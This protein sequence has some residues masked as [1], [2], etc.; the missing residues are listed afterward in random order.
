MRLGSKVS[1]LELL[2]E[3]HISWIQESLE[4]FL[5]VHAVNQQAFVRHLRE[6]VEN[7]A[8][9]GNCIIVGRGRVILPPKTTLK[10]RL[11]APLNS[12]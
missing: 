9:R 7:L 8:A 11:V 3:R 10:V 5:S 6:A 4:A 2:D 12:A 1:E